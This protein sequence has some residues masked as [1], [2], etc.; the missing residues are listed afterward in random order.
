MKVK[1]NGP[2][3]SQEISSRIF[4]PLYT[5]KDVGTGTGMGL[6][7]CHRIIEAHGGT[8]VLE[9]KPG[10]GAAFAIRLPRSHAKA[11]VVDR[12]SVVSD[13]VGKHR[14]LVVDDEFDVG[15]IISDVLEHAGHVVEV[16][17]SGKTALEKIGRCRYDV[18]LSDIRMP[19]MDGPAFY[20]ALSKTDPASINA[21]AFITGDTLS[22]NVK[23][24]L[25]AS[26][27]PYLEKPLMPGEIREL[28]E[29]LI[30]RQRE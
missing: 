15:E 17:G 5:T 23:A 22:P 13:P 16:A 10:E 21:L 12:R 25:E 30:R 7:L 28:V 20:Q 2:G 19:G 6:A 24:F 9:S 18:I 8:I 29:L 3:V 14:I 4:E 11:P 1:D 27:R 26:E